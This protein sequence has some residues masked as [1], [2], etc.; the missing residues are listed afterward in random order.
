MAAKSKVAQQHRN[1]L[2][3][4]S[5]A[6]TA[7]NID[8]ILGYLQIAEASIGANVG[9]LAVIT[10]ILGGAAELH[11]GDD[12]RGIVARAEREARHGG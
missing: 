4:E 9:F 3:G 8:S 1:P 2:I 7:D 6:E 12:Y 5:K 11:G 10:D